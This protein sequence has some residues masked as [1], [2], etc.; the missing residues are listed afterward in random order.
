MTDLARMRTIQRT[1][2][3]NQSS[4]PAETVRISRHIHY[5]KISVNPFQTELPHLVA[6]VTNAILV[7]E[8]IQPPAFAEQLLRTSFQL[9]FSL[10]VVGRMATEGALWADF[11]WSLVLD[12]AHA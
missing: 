8:T 12:S 9:T 6:Q 2:A 10:T 11:R 3:S 4:L 5:A 7:S 1:G